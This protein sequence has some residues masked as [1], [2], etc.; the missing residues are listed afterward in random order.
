MTS[1]YDVEVEL[2]YRTTVTVKAAG[3]AQ[4]HRDAQR[5]AIKRRSDGY[6]TEVRTQ[7]VGAKSSGER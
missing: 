2:T 7:I 4:A 6:F 5:V 1:T 3:A